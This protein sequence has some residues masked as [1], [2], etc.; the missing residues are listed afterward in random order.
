MN[1]GEALTT[2]IGPLPAWVYGLALGLGINGVRWYK[3][4]QAQQA[5]SAADEV[6][7][8][9]ASAAG[10]H[11]GKP[12][13][14]GSGYHTGDPLGSI[15]VGGSVGGYPIPTGYQMNPGGVITPSGGTSSGSTTAP[16]TNT[17]WSR[18]GFDLL[19][20]GGMYQPVAVQE[21]LRAFLAGDPVTAQQEAIVSEVLRRV[22]SPPEGA[23]ALSRAGA[24]SGGQTSQPPA[25][26][27][28]PPAAPAPTP[29]I[30]VDMPDYSQGPRGGW[31]IDPPTPKP[32]VGVG[33]GTPSPGVD[34]PDPISQRIAELVKR[35]Q[36]GP[37]QQD[38]YN[39]DGI[40]ALQEIGTITGRPTRTNAEYEEVKRD[41]YNWKGIAAQRGAA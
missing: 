33:P 10:A 40:A 23:P 37:T 5:A 2:K 35:V 13:P 38:P 20:G 27:S 24:S 15:S 22:G 9:T 26:P 8:G 14:G 32:S 36:R 41:P 1:V 34:V 6:S 39:W 17:D 4:Q 19:V 7:D 28:G 29:T 25:A 21:A 16:V 31:G 18:R 3:N 12:A 30:H 11:T